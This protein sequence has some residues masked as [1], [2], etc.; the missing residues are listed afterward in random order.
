MESTGALRLA[1]S[2]GQLVDW[3]DQRRIAREIQAKLR[4]DWP[5]LWTIV[6]PMLDPETQ[7][8]LK[9]MQLAG[10]M[11]SYAAVGYESVAE[12]TDRLVVRKEFPVTG[13]ITVD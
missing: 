4:V 6:R 7:E 11:E 13:Q 3:A 5:K 2:D 9:D 12:Y 1:V 8:S 10:V